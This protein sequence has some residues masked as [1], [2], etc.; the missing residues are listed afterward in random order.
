MED[1]LVDQPR[2]Q[3]L[4][5]HAAAHQADVLVAGR[6]AGGR[7]RVVDAGGDQGLPVG[8]RRRR[9]VAEDP[10]NTRLGVSP[11][12]CQSKS[13]VAS[14]SPRPGPG[15][16]PV[17]YP[18]TETAWALKTFVMSFSSRGSLKRP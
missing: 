9:P 6:R 2:A 8:D 16:R 11:S 17:M 14:P 18:S 15:S 13:D 4:G 12:P 5:H 7:D 3:R 10:S 1:H